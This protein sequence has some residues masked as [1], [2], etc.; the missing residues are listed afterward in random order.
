M[1]IAANEELTAKIKSA[2]ETTILHITD[3]GTEITK[4]ELVENLGNIISKFLH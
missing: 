2:K 1:K 3:T 4:N